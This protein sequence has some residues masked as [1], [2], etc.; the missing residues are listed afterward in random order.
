MPSQKNGDL[1]ERQQRFVEEYLKS[2]DNAA[3]AAVAAGYAES[4]AKSRAS[5][6]LQDPRIAKLVKEGK[7]Q[8]QE[9]SGIDAAWVLKR[10]ADEAEADLAEL[11][12]QD[13]SLK[14]VHEWPLIWRQ[15]LV[16]GIE[17]VSVGDSGAVLTKV[18]LSD[19][20]KRLELIGKHIDVSAFED[21]IV[22][23]PGEIN[24]VINR[25]DGAEPDSPAG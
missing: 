14:P 23:P 6:L 13:G 20:T 15:G 5:K 9:D 19:R 22:M 10:L 1:N 3:K 24:L 4:G 11:Y 18:R 7:A 25:P 21:R 16:A 12:E 8:A 2:P 17:S